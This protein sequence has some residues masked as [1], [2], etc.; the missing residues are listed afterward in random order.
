MFIIVKEAKN[1]D[2]Q[3]I[4][5]PVNPETLDELLK[6]TN[7]DQGKREFLIQGFTHGFKLQYQG[8]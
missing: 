4:I 7:Y 1:L 5:T 2:L 8:K 3:N 6:E